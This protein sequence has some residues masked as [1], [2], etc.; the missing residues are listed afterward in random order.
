MM[1]NDCRFHASRVFLVSINRAIDPT[2]DGIASHQP[3][4]VGPQQFGHRG[5]ILNKGGVVREG[6]ES[7]RQAETS[8]RA[9]EPRVEL[10]H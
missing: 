10:L 6:L 4:I 8:D 5:H 2:A 7:R 3:S 1:L 9:V